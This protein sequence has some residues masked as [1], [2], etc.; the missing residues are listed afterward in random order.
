MTSEFGLLCDRLERC[1]R[2]LVVVGAEALGAGPGLRSAQILREMEC[3]FESFLAVAESGC[4]GLAEAGLQSVHDGSK[5]EGSTCM[6][7]FLKGPPPLCLVVGARCAESAASSAVA[8]VWRAGGWIV[9]LGGRPSEL[10][11]LAREVHRGP[12]ADLLDELWDRFLLGPAAGYPGAHP[13]G[14]ES[15]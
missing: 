1:R 5:E 2:L 4:D 8:G 6:S 3:F 10:A 7:A 13:Q 14:R 9:E 12:A 15:R 11:A